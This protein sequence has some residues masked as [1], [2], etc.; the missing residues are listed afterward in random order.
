MKQGVVRWMKGLAQALSWALHPFV[1]PLYLLL[2]LFSRT[3]F[4]YFSPAVKGYLIGSVIL[5]G[6][7]LPLFFI[8]ALRYRGRLKN[9]RI[10]LR[11]ERILPLMIGAVCYM[12]CAVTIGRVESAAFLRKFMVAA[13]CCELMCA[14]VTTR[15]K[16]SLHM[17]GMGAAVALLV[18]L[19]LLALP[20]MLPPL[21]LTIAA[22]GVLASARLCLGRHT[23]WQVAAGFAG[24]FL[25][26]LVALFFF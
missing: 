7:A 10:E 6:V 3:A 13:G 17:T 19:N 23:P 1:L 14:I 22:A 25:I 12:L 26:A 20:H 24:G 18:V 11:E 5:Y 16:I 9:L 15:W 4:A 8:L 21:L 2:L